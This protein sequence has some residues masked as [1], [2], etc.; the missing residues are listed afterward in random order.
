MKS[1]ELLKN[2]PTPVHKVWRP[3]LLVSLVLHGIVLIL[4][5]PSTWEKSE[6]EE[7]VKVTQ[8]PSLSPSPK[9]SVNSAEAP[10][11]QTSPTPSQSTPFASA[12]SSQPTINPFPDPIQPTPDFSPTIEFSPGIWGNPK[13]SPSP[14]PSSSKDET[15][16]IEEKNTDQTLDSGIDTN[17]V[18]V[19]DPLEKFLT[20]FPFPEE[21]AIGSLGILTGEADTSARHVQQP[22]G[23]VIKYY[24][25]EL[26]D[27]NYTLANPSIDEPDFKVYRV[28]QDDVSQY[29]HLI[30]KGENTIISLS[31]TQLDR[32]DL[33][34]LTAE[35]AEER[36]LQNILEQII[37]AGEHTKELNTEIKQVLAEGVEG[38][39]N[40][41]GTV[42]ERDKEQLISQFVS[43]LEEK[44]FTVIPLNDD[45][46]LYYSVKKNDFKGFIQLIPTQSGLAI[47][48]LEF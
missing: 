6:P 30:L 40:Y 13:S 34:E 2:L 39:Y 14:S 26:P 8:L 18:N 7:Q 10:T 27:R 25:K 31:K 35:K 41:L 21:A 3:M 37:V 22:L 29:L 43:Q 12:F 17:D 36:E 20:N 19:E 46:G 45:D 48:N 1:P 28:S 9:S 47:I 4:P 11:A 24:S 23:Q 44:E 5:V 38:K 15:Q 42:Y 33:P 32:A 16:T